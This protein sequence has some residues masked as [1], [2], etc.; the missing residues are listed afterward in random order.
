V[1]LNLTKLDRIGSHAQEL[2]AAIAPHLRDLEAA[3]ADDPEL[4]DETAASILVYCA[5][6]L[7]MGTEGRGVA[8]HRLAGMVEAAGSDFIE[9]RTY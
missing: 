8:L 1:T 7:V 6:A 9:P 5:V 3:L 4:P 2:G